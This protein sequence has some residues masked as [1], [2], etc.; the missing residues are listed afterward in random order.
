MGKKW[1]PKEYSK[2][3]SFTQLN[4]TAIGMN[5][6]ERAPMVTGINDENHNFLGRINDMEDGEK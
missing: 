1:E 6:L 2:K 3:G 5:A 4:P